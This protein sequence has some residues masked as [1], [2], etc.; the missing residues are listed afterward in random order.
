MTI[1]SKKVPTF[2]TNNEIY[3]QESRKTSFVG[4]YYY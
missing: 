3:G 1:L 2:I 4:F